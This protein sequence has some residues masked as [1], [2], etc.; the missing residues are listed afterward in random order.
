MGLGAVGAGFAIGLANMQAYAAIGRNP[1]AEPMIRSNYILGLVFAETL[2][3][4]SLLI[5]FLLLFHTF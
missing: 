5:A 3:I 1:S 4:Y 2:A